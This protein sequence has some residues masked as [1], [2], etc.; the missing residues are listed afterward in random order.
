MFGAESVVFETK[1]ALRTGFLLTVLSLS[2]APLEAQNQSESHFAHPRRIRSFFGVFQEREIPVETQLV[3]MGLGDQVRIFRGRTEGGTTFEVALR[4]GVFAEFDLAVSSFDF[5]VADF[6]VGFPVTVRHGKFS[7]RFRL[8]HQSSHLGDDILGRDDIVL[9]ELGGFDFEA[10]EVFTGFD[11][12]PVYPYAGAEY[13]F[14]RTPGFQDASVFHL[15]VSARPPMGRASLVF[16]GG[17][18]ATFSGN[19][20]GTPGLSA[21]AGV[22]WRRARARGAE[23]ARSIRLL[24]EGRRGAA[25]AG[26]FFQLERST[27][28]VV[29]E[30]GR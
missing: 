29:V 4:A 14:R 20:S 30:I 5:F 19:G 18:H 21:R 7:G 10:L 1:Q 3:K 17:A 11:A 25:G 8:Y 12:G 23:P 27:F 16:V 24:L 2:V 26:R 22:E 9:E 28:G 13:R 15:G 6:L